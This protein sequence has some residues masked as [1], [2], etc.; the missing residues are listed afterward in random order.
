LRERNDKNISLGR[1]RAAAVHRENRLAREKTLFEESQKDLEHYRNDP[2]FV[3]GVGLYWAE[4]A[5]RASSFAFVN[6]DEDMIHLMILW[7]EKYLKIQRETFN[8]RLY[9][10]KP[11]AHERCE[12]HWSNRTGIPLTNFRKT[13]FKPSGLGVKKR[14]NYKGCIRIMAGGTWALRKV[15]F[16]QHLLFGELKHRQ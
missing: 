4:G 5:K 16:W 1:I 11:Y 14:P 13:I 2:L 6:S 8:A 9:I 10:H 15:T 12:E 3:L 7:I